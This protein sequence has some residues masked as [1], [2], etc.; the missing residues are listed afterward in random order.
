MFSDE[1]TTTDAFLDMPAGSQLLY[2]HLGMEADDDGFISSP[3]MVMR[4]IGASDD[5]LKILISK[6]FLLPF[7]NGVCVV[8]H[9]RINNN[10]RKDRYS[11]TKYIKEKSQLFIRQNGAYT[12]NSDDALPV[13]KG[14]FLPSGLPT[15]DQ[16]T[17]SGQ[18][19]IGKDRIDND[20]SKQKSSSLK[21]GMQTQETEE[22]YL[23]GDGSPVRPK[24]HKTP[25]SSKHREIFSL[26]E[27]GSKLL[28]K[29]FGIPP[30]TGGKEYKAIERALTHVKPQ[31]VLLMIEDSI[32]NGKAEKNNMSFTA[33]FSTNE[34]NRYRLENHG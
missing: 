23:D 33:I 27:K 21:K 28:E 29:E 19:S 2:F 32:A 10:I 24:A 4:V 6:K 14:H 17:T 30:I 31:D 22:W 34:L 3:K 9:W 11:E 12:F 1:V 5:E 16:I 13:P 25:V 15:V 26:M 8:K 7:P 20:F 18:P